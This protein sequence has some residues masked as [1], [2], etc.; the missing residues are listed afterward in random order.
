V[1][2][3]DV[4]VDRIQRFA[5]LHKVVRTN[6]WAAKMRNN[7]A[8]C[9]IGKCFLSHFWPGFGFTTGPAG[10]AIFRFSENECRID[11]ARRFF[12]ARAGGVNQTT[13]CSTSGDLD[14]T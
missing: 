14:P 4:E 2:F 1:K 8:I 10:F 5:S 7:P 6:T 3:D 9:M 13:L 11:R 12:R